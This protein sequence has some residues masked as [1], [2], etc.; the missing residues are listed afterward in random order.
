MAKNDFRFDGDSQ[1]RF[2]AGILS[3]LE[4]FGDPANKKARQ[5]VYTIVIILAVA[6][7]VFAYSKQQ[8]KGLQANWREELGQAMALSMQGKSAEAKELYV[9]FLANPA[10]NGL[11][12]AKAS[13]LLAD[14]YYYE[15]DYSAA[16]EKYQGALLAGGASE[17]VTSGAEHGLAAVSI[18][19]KEYDKA[20]E[21][22]EK[23]IGKWSTRESS[24]SGEFG[25]DDA[26]VQVP[27]ALVQL[28]LVYKEL[29]DKD[30][31][32]GAVEKVLSVYPDS[33]QSGAARKILSTL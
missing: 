10:V 7:A 5:T 14:I 20:A 27:E 1:D 16:A 4:R 13:L 23:F 12:K 19:K 25:G 9:K 15:G 28:S 30:K 18:Q 22:L 32:R 26:I 24:L 17:L 21:Q 31:A 11:F 2:Q 29:G 6:L 8:Q 33:R 3:M